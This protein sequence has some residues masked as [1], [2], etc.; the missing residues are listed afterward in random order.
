MIACIMATAELL[1]AAL[2]V[3]KPPTVTTMP[4]CTTL[5][6]VVPDKLP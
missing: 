6:E 4:V 3:V 5:H 1:F 2:T